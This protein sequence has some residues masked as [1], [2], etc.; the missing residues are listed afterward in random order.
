[1]PISPEAYHLN[2][3]MQR[4]VD[5]A[6][7][8]FTEYGVDLPSKRYWTAGT[9][10]IDCEQL[11]VSL[12]QLYLG[13]P[14]DQAD[15][16]QRLMVPRTA[17]CTLTIARNVPTVGQNG[18]SPD[19]AKIQEYAGNIA[20]D[21]WILVDTVSRFDQWEAG[22]FGVGVIATVDIAEPEGGLQAV[23]MQLTMAVP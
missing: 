15:A 4:I 22:Q 23:N 20:V 19:A 16:P 12:V 13:A 21:A 3:F 17:V 7:E 10:V 14:G 1:M 11:V 6:V 9:A 5:T 8:I 18:R 2:T